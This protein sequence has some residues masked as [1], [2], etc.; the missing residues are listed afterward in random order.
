M[1]FR[2]HIIQWL[3]WHFLLL[4]FLLCPSLHHTGFLVASP[5][6]TLYSGYFAFTFNSDP[7]S[8]PQICLFLSCDACFNCPVGWN[9]LLS[10]R[11][12]QA[13]QYHSVFLFPLNLI[14][15]AMVLLLIYSLMMKLFHWVMIFIKQ[16]LEI[17]KLIYSDMI[18]YGLFSP[19]W[20]GNAM[21]AVVVSS[22]LRKASGTMVGVHWRFLE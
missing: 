19:H 7:K 12:S 18:V 1:A 11:S 20:H 6:F 16:I 14:Y 22:V 8:L 21:G 10:V 13:I 2:I 15:S 3:L 9:V 4:V 5:K 17:Q